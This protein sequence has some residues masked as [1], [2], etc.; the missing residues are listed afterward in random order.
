MTPRESTARLHS[1][2]SELR[3]A[4]QGTALRD[5]VG[6][7]LR[8][9]DCAL[10]L[11]ALREDPEYSFVIYEVPRDVCSKPR[12]MLAWLLERLVLELSEED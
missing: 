10:I 12:E 4:G 3:D 7:A 9:E 1:L 11:R 5:A 8:G 2:V 6:R